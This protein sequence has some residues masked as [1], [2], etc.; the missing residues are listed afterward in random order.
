VAD[1]AA[2]SYHLERRTE[3]LARSAWEHVRAIEARGGAAACL[4]DGWWQEQLDAVWAQIRE[5]FEAGEAH[6]LG[7]S[8][9]RGEDMLE[10]S[11]PE[12]AA[13]AYGTRPFPLRRPAALFEG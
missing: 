2:G 7:A 5:S 4:L 8:Q 11:S 9:H 13:S 10:H 6:V 3:E 1:P 12:P